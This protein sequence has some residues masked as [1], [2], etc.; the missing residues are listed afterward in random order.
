MDIARYQV[1]A[2]DNRC[3]SIRS[4]IFCLQSAHTY[5]PQIQQI[6]E[7]SSFM[8]LL[9]SHYSCSQDLLLV[10]CRARRHIVRRLLLL[11]IHVHGARFFVVFA[12]PDSRT[13]IVSNFPS[14]ATLLLAHHQDAKRREEKKTAL[15][16]RDG[17]MGKLLATRHIHTNIY[18][19]SSACNTR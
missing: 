3:R 6:C 12:P 2:N 7:K 18:Y 8:H 10:S 1:N 15:N 13:Y 4:I 5:T 14:A 9:V 17:Y 16:V 11:A 19:T